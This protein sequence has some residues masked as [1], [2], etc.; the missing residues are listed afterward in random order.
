VDGA[1]VDPLHVAQTGALGRTQQSTGKS[2][3]RKA[4]IAL[5]LRNIS[6]EWLCIQCM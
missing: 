4:S 3:V 6:G 5:A 1:A 2:T